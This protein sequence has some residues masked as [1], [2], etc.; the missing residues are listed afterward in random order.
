M[1]DFEQGRGETHR[2][3]GGTVARWVSCLAAD[4]VGGRCWGSSCHCLRAV[5]RVW[6]WSC[7][8][9]WLSPPSGPWPGRS[10]PGRPTP[11]VIRSLPLRM[12][13]GRSGSGLF[14]PKAA[15]RQGTGR[16]R[17]HFG[18][19]GERRKGCRRGTPSGCYRGLTRRGPTLGTS[20]EQRRLRSGW[21][22][23]PARS[24]QSLRVAARRSIC[25]GFV[26]WWWNI[27][28]WLAPARTGS[29]VMTGATTPI[30]RL[31]ASWCFGIWPCGRS[32]RGATRMG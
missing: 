3:R 7:N 2:F 5:F 8:G 21:G 19:W 26:M 16:G 1:L 13:S 12:D 30:P 27:L 9:S 31:R 17:R 28:R 14:L 18:R 23:C 24:A 15:T 11:R 22:A 29:T 20:R 32:A 6:E 4:R 10:W 25:P